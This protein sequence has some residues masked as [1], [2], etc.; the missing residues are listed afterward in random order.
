MRKVPGSAGDGSG[1]GI[2]YCIVEL[3]FVDKSTKTIIL[4]YFHFIPSQRHRTAA[5]TSPEPREAHQEEAREEQGSSVRLKSTGSSVSRASSSVGT[6]LRYAR[7]S[8]S[9]VG[10]IAVFAE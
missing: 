9:G 2:W 1:A 4:F 3:Y 6:R 10:F 8:V 5:A 7:R